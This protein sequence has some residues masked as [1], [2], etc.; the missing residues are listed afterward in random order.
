MRF[1]F[2]PEGALRELREVA[3]ISVSISTLASMNDFGGA[4]FPLPKSKLGPAVTPD[5]APADAG[6][7]GGAGTTS[8]EGTTGSKDGGQ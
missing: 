8:A 5:G 1:D 6:A 2:T 4:G 3:G 7:Q